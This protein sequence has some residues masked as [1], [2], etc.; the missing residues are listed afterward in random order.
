M[1]N[2][3]VVERTEGFY[4]SLLL[5]CSER[6]QL[7]WLEYLILLFRFYRHILLGGEIDHLVWEQLDTQ[8]EL[9]GGAV[10]DSSCRVYI[11]ILFKVRICVRY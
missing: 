8:E 6:S 10:V 9:N 4:G 5:P 11:R 2:V 1:F 3:H 7:R